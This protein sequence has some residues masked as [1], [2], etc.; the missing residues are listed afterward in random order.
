MSPPVL[1]LMNFGN[2]FAK[3]LAGDDV[4]RDVDGDGRHDDGEHRH[5]DDDRRA[6]F[7]DQLHGIPDRLAVD[8]RGGAGDHHAHRRK[9]RHRRRQRDD[10]ADDLLALA[11]A[12]AREV[13]HVERERRPEA[14]HR[15]ER[16]HEHGPELA[17][18]MKF[19][20]LTQQGAEP[21]RAADRPPHQHGGHHQHERRGPVFHL[22]HQV[23]AA[24]NDVDVEAPEQQKRQPFGCRVTAEAGTEQRRPA[25]HDVLKNMFTASPP[26]Q[27]WMPNQPH[28]TSARISAGH[29]RAE[30][31]VGR[32]REHR[33]RDAVFR[34]GMRVQQNRNQDD[35]VAEQDREQRL[36]PVH[37]GRHQARGEHV[38]RDA[39]RH[40][41]PQ[42]GVV[43]GRPGAPADGHRGQVGVVE[44]ARFHPRRIDELHTAVWE[45]ALVHVR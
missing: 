14:D 31:A 28:A 22:A 27:A 7:T 32:A 35:G 19:S 20:R 8:D 16:G 43:V 39:V 23:H 17:E 25:R 3:S 12:E 11:A 40:A 24:I 26:I 13:G 6:E 44:R 1:K 18:G 38:G 21:M 33:K 41:D 2:A 29:V 5:R 9:H 4:R 45:T 42:R 36:P 15:R 37:P 34:A 30:G 10:L